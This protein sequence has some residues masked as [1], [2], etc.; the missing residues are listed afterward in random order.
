MANNFMKGK[1][2]FGAGADDKQKQ[3]FG[4]GKN[5]KGV[6]ASSKKAGMPRKSGKR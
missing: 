2:A 3:S 5:F 6:G 4:G 1:K